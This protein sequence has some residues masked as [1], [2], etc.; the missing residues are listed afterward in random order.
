MPTTSSEIVRSNACVGGYACE[1]PFGVEEKLFLGLFPGDAT[2]LV[3]VSPF[4]GLFSGYPLASYPVSLAELATAFSFPFTTAS[5]DL[6][7]SELDFLEFLLLFSLLGYRSRSFCISSIRPS[8]FLLV[9]PRLAPGVECSY[10]GGVGTTDPSTP[11]VE[12][13][14]TGVLE[15]EEEMRGEVIRDLRELKVFNT[16][17]V[18]AVVNAEE[19]GAAPFARGALDDDPATLTLPAPELPVTFEPFVLT[20]CDALG[21]L[22]VRF[23]K[24][25]IFKQACQVRQSSNSKTLC[26]CVVSDS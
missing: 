15:E 6:L 4:L 18:K 9:L 25:G 10:P 3:E 7:L 5:F 17:E 1:L 14:G 21:R 23:R 8:S 24:L 12:P 2:P 22:D 13:P 20:G 16:G 26:V 11:G 19:V